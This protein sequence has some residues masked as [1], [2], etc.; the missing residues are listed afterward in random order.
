MTISLVINVSS[1][2]AVHLPA[3]ISVKKKKMH[4]KRSDD[5]RINFSSYS[6]LADPC[7]QNIPGPNVGSA[8]APNPST[9]NNPVVSNISTSP[10]ASSTN[11]Q[12]PKREL[13]S[14]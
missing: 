8:A 2:Q 11:H 4:A 3:V 13:V 12:S 5:E 14:T 7:E 1:V 9:S 10:T 6:Y